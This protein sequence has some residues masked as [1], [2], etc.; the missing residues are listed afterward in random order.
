LRVAT[1]LRRAGLVA[2]ADHTSRRLGKQ[3]EAAA[4]AGA[5]FAVI[6]GDELAEG[7]VQLKD[8]KAGTQRQIGVDDLA[9]DLVRAEGQHRHGDD[10]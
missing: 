1:R 2:W 6:C 8:L 10:A 9:R 3:I 5:H 4:R 7:I